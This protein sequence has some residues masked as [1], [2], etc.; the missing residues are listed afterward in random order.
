MYLCI[1]GFLIEGAPDDSLKFEWH[2]PSE[3]E[4]NVMT[5]LGWKSLVDE[6]DGELLLTHDQ[7]RKISLLVKKPLPSDL[8]L[9]IG[10]EGYR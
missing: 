1:T 9:F 3:F 5:V 2:V 10:V 6:C 8:D 7:V 4:L